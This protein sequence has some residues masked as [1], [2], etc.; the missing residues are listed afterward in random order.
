MPEG[1]A[2]CAVSEILRDL[3]R[4][5]HGGADKVRERAALRTLKS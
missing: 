4:L 3:H 1:E 5:Q 2:D